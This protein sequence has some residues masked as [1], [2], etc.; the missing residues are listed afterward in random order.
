MAEAATD[1]FRTVF[2]SPLPSVFSIRCVF[3]DAVG[4]L[5]DTYR[6]APP[7]PGLAAGCRLAITVVE[8]GMIS[9]SSS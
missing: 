6:A 9:V 2:W 1:A 3:L 7:R 5:P 4:A 8:R